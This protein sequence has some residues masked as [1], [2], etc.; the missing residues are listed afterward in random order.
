MPWHPLG[1]VF[2]Q[3][4]RH[5]PSI[6]ITIIIDEFDEIPSDLYPSIDNN[7]GES[8]FLN[9]RALS[10]KK[11][12]CCVLVGGENMRRIQH[13]TDKLNQFQ[14][15]QVDYLNKENYWEDFRALVQNPVKDKIDYESA[16]IDALYDVTA[17]NP[18]FTKMLCGNIYSDVCK[19]RDAYI[20]EEDVQ[21]TIRNT[22][23]TLDVQNMNHFWKDG[24]LENDAEQCKV[25]ETLRIK[26][27]RAFADLNRK[28]Q[29]VTKDTLKSTDILQP[30]GGAIEPIID[31][32][33]TRKIFFEQD[34]HYR[35]KP[36]LLEKW[37]VET[38][39]H[40]MGEFERCC[41]TSDTYGC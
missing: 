34:S 31:S 37:L 40:N 5:Q 7:I 19:T 30:S 6:K 21:K 24:I 23:L 8:F 22:S 26:V 38:G 27:L 25:I 20:T 15:F 11:H 1:D 17:G 39:G 9:I 41:G 28:Q 10:Q 4:R 2:D 36:L 13:S 14:T 32:F 16:A 18:F 29:P 35:C 33:V 12:V 3:I